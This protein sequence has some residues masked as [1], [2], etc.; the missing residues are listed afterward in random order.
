MRRSGSR[1]W[2][3]CT[4]ASTTASLPFNKLAQT[5]LCS[6][7][8][9]GDG[10]APVLVSMRNRLATTCAGVGIQGS[11]VNTAATVAICLRLVFRP[12]HRPA[13]SLVYCGWTMGISLQCCEIR[14]IEADDV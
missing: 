9:G 14:N 7:R 11:L 12:L 5:R 1:R 10:L 2:T 3:S 8:G 6:G 4:T 13:V